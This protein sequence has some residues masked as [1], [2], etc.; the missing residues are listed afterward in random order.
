[1]RNQFH[2]SVCVFPLTQQPRHDV[3]GRCDVAEIGLVA[4]AEVVE[5][6]L[7]VRAPDKAIFRALAVAREPELTA[8]T[9]AWQRRLFFTN[10]RFLSGLIDQGS[11]VIRR[12]VSQAIL[13]IHEMVAG[14]D[15]T[16]MLHNR[17]L[18]TARTEDACTRSQLAP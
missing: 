7:T 5:P 17:G 13:R 14:V 3:H 1:M 10:Q 12:Q 9:L 18:A 4:G 15:A 8:H 11:Q 6:G 2:D 16:V